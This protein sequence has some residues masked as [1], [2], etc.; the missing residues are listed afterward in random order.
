MAGK[1]PPKTSKGNL[2]KRLQEP[3][4]ADAIH[5][6]PGPGG[7]S[8]NYAKAHYV[9]KRLIDVFGLKWSAKTINTPLIN[10]DPA[11][12]K[13]WIT[14][15]VRVAVEI[16][17]QVWEKDGWDSV[18]I[19][20]YSKGY[21]E[22][23]WIDLGNNYKQAYS[24]A[25]KK[26]VTQL[27]IALYLYFGEG[28]LPDELDI[29]STV[30][31]TPEQNVSPDVEPVSPPPPSWGSGAVSPPETAQDFQED[32]TPV[33][34]GEMPDD[35]FSSADS[36]GTGVGLSS[37]PGTPVVAEA[38]MRVESSEEKPS[39]FMLNAIKL[40]IDDGMRNGKITGTIEEFVHSVVGVAAVPDKLTKPQAASVL[41]HLSEMR[42]G[43]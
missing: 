10:T 7:Q 28:G 19:K 20:T 42:K 25:L 40:G 15:G 37:G 5:S 32:S 30:D 17:G 8:Y 13:Q 24:Q 33:I 9:I 16:D 27:G 38:T 43:A 23:H 29:G 4:E 36:V 1:H 41:D 35:L 11:S 6:V 18:E 12:H 2:L 31:N 34:T 39:I 21:K 22:G 3:F 26:A 14:M